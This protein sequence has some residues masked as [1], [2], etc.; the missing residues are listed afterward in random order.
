MKLSKRTLDSLCCPVCKS[1]LVFGVNYACS[2]IQCKNS[3][4][5]IN[6]TPVLI[7]EANSI[8]SKSDFVAGK[9]T[10]IDLKKRSGVKKLLTSFVPRITQN[11]AGEKNYTYLHELLKKKRTPNVLIIGCGF[12]GKGL[13][14]LLGDPLIEVVE[15]DVALGPRTA[16]ICDAHD[17]PFKEN[18]FDAV[19]VQAVLEHVLDPYRCVAE[20][21]R[22]LKDDGIVYA[23]T[24]FMQQVH[25]RE[26]DFTR[27]TQLGHR[28]LF[29]YFGELDSGAAVGP[30]TALAWAY[31]YFLLSFTRRRL[32]R[33]FIIVF[34]SFT[35]FYLK[36]FDYW[37]VKK[38]GG[39]DA[40]S[41]FY[42]IGV[43]SNAPL[44]DKELLKQY[45][46]AF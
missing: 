39:L 3:Y 14:K 34:A 41:G 43:K 44:S 18:T 13:G 5:V 6:G 19:I 45:R 27:F 8:F 20:I 46:G 12:V 36:Y 28:R 31:Q 40:A 38:P 35:S 1:D 21:H 7:N 9:E 30:G 37:L 42:F 29:R 25:M 2:N 15:S 24:P 17:I 11:I 10:T 23:E 22:V 33:K 4:P 26:Y 32:L 16:L